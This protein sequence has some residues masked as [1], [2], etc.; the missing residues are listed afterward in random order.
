MCEI[1]LK[2]KRN[3]YIW[4]KKIMNVRVKLDNVDVIFSPLRFGSTPPPSASPSLGEPF[5]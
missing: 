2:C 5:I 3:I 4:K 1:L